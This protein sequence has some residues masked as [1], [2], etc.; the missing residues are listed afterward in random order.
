MLLLAKVKAIIFL[1]CSS[2]VL[3]KHLLLLMM[4]CAI[5]VPGTREMLEIQRSRGPALALG[6][7]QA[8]RRV[9]P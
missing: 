1:T 6:S 2:D 7:S 5:S 4:I 3:N 9:V 8:S